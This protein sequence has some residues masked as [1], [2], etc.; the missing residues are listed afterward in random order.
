MSDSEQMS[1]EV[2]GWSVIKTNRSLLLI[3][4]SA[5]RIEA[6]DDGH[7]YNNIDMLRRRHPEKHFLR[8]FD[9]GRTYFWVLCH[10]GSLRTFRT[11]GYIYLQIGRDTYNW[12]PLQLKELTRKLNGEPELGPNS[13]IIGQSILYDRLIL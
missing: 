7:R 9:S 13:F 11:C 6:S 1:D 2:P 5:A 4:L 12:S 3:D 8:N 10:G